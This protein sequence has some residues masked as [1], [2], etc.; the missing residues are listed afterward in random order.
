MTESRKE[1]EGLRERLSRVVH[2]YVRTMQDGNS[3]PLER[4]LDELIEQIQP[5]DLVELGELT[6]AE[7]E[8]LK[9]KWAAMYRWEVRPVGK[10][11][12]TKANG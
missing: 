6:E 4:M 3:A 9:A 12:R 7:F 11:Q 5:T 10:A 1:T 8:E 2:K